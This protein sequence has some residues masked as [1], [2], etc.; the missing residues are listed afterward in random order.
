MRHT[1]VAGINFSG[2]TA[3]LKNLISG[4][5]IK[6]HEYMRVHELKTRARTLYRECARFHLVRAHLQTDLHEIWNLSSLDRNWPPH[7]IS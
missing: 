4:P 7:K 5:F 1:S 2:K 6:I 3:V